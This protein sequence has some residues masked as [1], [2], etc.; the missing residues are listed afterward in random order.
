MNP[1][2]AAAPRYHVLGIYGIHEHQ[3]YMLVQALTVCEGGVGQVIALAMASILSSWRWWL[4][5]GQFNFIDTGC[6]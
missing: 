3:Y 6:R 4:P 1:V 5:S 2:P